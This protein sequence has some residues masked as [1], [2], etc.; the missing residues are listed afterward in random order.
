MTTYKLS[1]FQGEAPSVSDRALGGSFA[2]VNENLFLP[3]GEFWPLAQDVRHSACVPGA[4]TLH[5]FGR[6][7]SGQVVQ[8]PEAA[9]RSFAQHLS[10]VKGQINDEA[11]ERTY[12][13]Y[14]DGSA[15]PR[16]QDARGNDR[17][18]G[19]V[20][21]ARP[22]VQAQLVD[23]F[24]PGEAQNW[25]YGDFAQAVLERLRASEVPHTSA[26]QVGVRWDSAGASYSGT[27]SNAGLTLATQVPGGNPA[28]L[29]AVVSDAR[30]QAVDMDVTRL[31]ALQVAGG[32]AVPLQAM[33][34]SYPLW[35]ANLVQA[36]QLLEFPEFAGERAG[37]AVLSGEQATQLVTMASTQLAA[38]VA[39]DKYRNELT[40]LVSE[41]AALALSKAWSV[42]ASRPVAPTLPKRT[43]AF[44][45]TGYSEAEM[46]AYDAATLAYQEALADYN[47]GVAQAD[48]QSASLN[49]RMQEIQQRS[50]A[51]VNAIDSQLL[52]QRSALLGDVSMVSRYLDTLGGVATLAGGD[53]VERVVD[54]R[55]YVVAFVTDWGEESEPSPVSEMLEVDANDTVKVL[56]P[57]AVTGEVLAAR[58]IGTWRIYRSNTSD[59]AAAWQL[60]AEVPASVAA[61][62]DD[63]PSSQLDNLQPQFTWAAPPYRMD[64][65]FTG[66]LKP[67]VGS[68]PYLRG[69]VGM[70]NGIMAGFIDNTVAFCEPYVP[71]AWPVEYQVTTEYPVV[72][73]GVFDQTLFV[74]TTGNPYFI[75]GAHSASMSALKLDSNQSCAA[76]RSIVGV[77]GGVLYA[78]P[79]GLCLANASGVQVVTRQLM[80][81]GD[82]QKLQPSSMFAA[83]HEG[84]YYLFYAGSGGGCLA[85]DLQNGWKLGRV[86]L[87]GTAVWVDKLNDLMYVAKGQDIWQCFSGQ[88]LRAGRWRAGV[89]T[90][91]AQHPLAW[92]KVYGEQSAANP[93][94]VRLWGDG[95]LRHT[96]VFTDLKPQR[97]PPG[98][99]LEHQVEIEGAAR[100]TSVVLC[101]ISEELRAV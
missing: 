41:F 74:G 86:T 1:A 42:P 8:S 49:A 62:L 83:E 17:L 36:L 22:T 43:G 40:A 33:P 78:S 14:N 20:R 47:D 11:S 94:T 96:A 39:V 73:L 5:R 27:R 23:E 57:L 67:T 53:L 52:D 85:F 77:Q 13:T 71:Y 84:V 44:L 80:A 10:L 3:S 93:V 58:S 89:A 55:Y 97:L 66:T 65:Q 61:F 28:C 64:G 2:R 87:S 72:G 82:W 54:A 15:P 30:V 75:T 68:N 50:A 29:Y 21:P 51:L 79:D 56:R 60:V 9:I 38:G 4:L 24:T 18:L 59:T 100:L 91:P 101:S 31:S 12:V 45:T 70:P 46:E 69:L 90:E 7:A 32:W 76:A 98:R 92:V 34:L 81:R 35:Q 48:S 88:A 26:T 95:Q 25:I 37:Q 16:V 6:N 19:V 99:W 63:K